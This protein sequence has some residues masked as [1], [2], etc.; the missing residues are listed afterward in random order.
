M[1]A[2]AV[3]GLLVGP[4]LGIV[5]D[6]IIERESLEMNHRC[7]VCGSNLGSASIIPVRSWFVRCPTDPGH[8][9]WRYAVTDV[10]TAVLFAVAAN[11]FGWTWQLWP[12]LALFALFVVMA[13]TD[14]EHHLLVNELTKSTFV[15][16]LGSVLILGGLVGR[17]DAIWPA[18]GA[19]LFAGIF[20]LVFHLI[21][22]PGL[23]LGD[24]KLAPSIGLFVGWLGEDVLDGISLTLNALVVGMLLGGVVGLV[25]RRWANGQPAERFAD[26]PEEWIPGE[27]P[28]GPFLIVGAVILIAVT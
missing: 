17:E 15:L 14:W 2:F 26:Q 19:G 10:M 20:F 6:R 27:V 24:V 28:L 16:A 11:R 18:I 3:V 5:V 21:Y 4:F 7:P 23:G 12:Y 25:L 22:P 9:R 8:S 13:I 1:L